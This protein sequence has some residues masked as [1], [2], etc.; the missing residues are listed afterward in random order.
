MDRPR[1]TVFLVAQNRLV[2]EALSGILSKRSELKQV[3]C[4][5]FSPDSLREII[6]AAPDVLIMDGSVNNLAQGEFV[7]EL[8]T[9]LPRLRVMI[10]GA[11]LDGQELLR[12]IRAGVMGYVTKDAR[13]LEI[14][15]A[16]ETVARGGAVCCPQLCAFLFRL[17]AQ[18]DQMP[19]FRI[20]SR[21][22]LTSREQQVVGLISQGLT[23]KEIA[24]RLHLA[25]HTVRNHVHHLLKKLGVKHRL[26]AVDVCR[27]QGSDVGA[28]L[29]SNLP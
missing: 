8:Q 22:G 29:S 18:C 2:R 6:S 28:P 9:N 15:A 3:G 10:I 23:N 24:D 1:I 27:E 14:V 17:A 20:F 4:S 25:E 26:A 12:S 7:R 13:A 19:N 5:D 16:V 11:E 21:L